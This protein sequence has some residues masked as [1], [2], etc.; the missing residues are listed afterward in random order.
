MTLG[1]KKV[2]TICKSLFSE[3]LSLNEPESITKDTDELKQAE[4]RANQARIQ[5]LERM[6]ND[7][8]DTKDD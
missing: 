7:V 3:L 8:N 2:L 6:F 4:E 1:V 5:N